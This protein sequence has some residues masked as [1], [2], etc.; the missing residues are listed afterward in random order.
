MNWTKIVDDSNYQAEIVAGEKLTGLKGGFGWQAPPAGY[1]SGLKAFGAEIPTI[2][3]SEWSA[4]IKALKEQKRNISHCQKWSCDNQGSNPTCWAAG[5]CQA[6]ATARVLAMGIEH[7]IRYSAMSL[8]VPI[9]GGNSG[10][11]EEEAVDYAA[12]HGVVDSDF[13]GYTDRSRKDSDPKVQANRA[14][15]KCLESYTCRGDDEFATALLLGFPC[16]VSYSWWSHV[17]MLTDLVEI[18]SGSYGF[19]IRNNWGDGYGDKNEYGFGG[20]A[21]FRFGKGSPSG[22]VAIRQMTSA[23][24][25]GNHALAL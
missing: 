8:A 6:M 24:K 11:W 1:S 12:K 9:S 4:R 13:W 20:Y 10:G 17:V 25:E 2:P 7:H 22:G 21:V 14:M 5:T 3:R 19:L 23:L 18:E 15:H 16:T